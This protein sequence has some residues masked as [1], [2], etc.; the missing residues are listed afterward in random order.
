MSDDHSSGGLGILSVIQI[1]FLIL[2][3]A[4]IVDWSWGIV[5]IPL[6]IELGLHLLLLFIAWIVCGD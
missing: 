2:K 3:F 6:W 4:N 1:V 5:L